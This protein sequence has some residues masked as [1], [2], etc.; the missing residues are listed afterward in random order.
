MADEL[1][2]VVAHGNIFD[3][4]GSAGKFLSV[5][6]STLNQLLVFIGILALLDIVHTSRSLTIIENVDTTVMQNRGPAAGAAANLASLQRQVNKA[7]LRLSRF[8]KRSQSAAASQKRLIER[9]EAELAESRG[10]Q[11]AAPQEIDDLRREVESS[12]LLDGRTIKTEDQFRTESMLEA[13]EQMQMTYRKKQSIATKKFKHV[14]SAALL[15]QMVP[16]KIA[17]EKDD[18]KKAPPRRPICS[19]RPSCAPS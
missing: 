5:H 4:S 7:G 14:L 1:N 6:L 9:L 15:R 17:F 12:G 16:W 2:A 11:A 10:L 8:I 18:K 3:G 19:Q 13:I